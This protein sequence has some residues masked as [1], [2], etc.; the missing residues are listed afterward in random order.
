MEGTFKEF[1]KTEVNA[2]VIEQG[3]A[4]LKKQKAEQDAAGQPS[5]PNSM[6]S[7]N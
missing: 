7:P 2:S 6:I 1:K 4:Q 5:R 3:L